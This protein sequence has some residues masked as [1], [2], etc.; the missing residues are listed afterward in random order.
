ML[1][2][3]N[4]IRQQKVC[5]QYINQQYINQRQLNLDLHPKV[6]ILDIPNLEINKNNKNNKYNVNEIKK[7]INNTYYLKIIGLN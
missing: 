3:Q 5:E 4:I 7:R 2:H 6:V 1:K